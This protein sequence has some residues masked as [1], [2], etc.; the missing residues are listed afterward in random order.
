MLIQSFINTAGFK[1]I[2]SQEIIK[3]LYNYQKGN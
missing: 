2:K 1:Q 3:S